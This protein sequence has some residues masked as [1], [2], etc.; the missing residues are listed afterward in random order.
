M[1]AAYYGDTDL[2]VARAATFVEQLGVGAANLVWHPG[3]AD[4]RRTA[5]FEDL[6]RDLGLV[7]YWRETGGWGDF[8]QPLREGGFEC[9]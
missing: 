1:W 5:A 7:D 3:L 8:C 4:A 9:F 2:A 6:V